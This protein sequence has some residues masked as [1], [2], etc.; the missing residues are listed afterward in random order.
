MQRKL[1]LP[2]VKMTK[3]KA[4]LQHQYS[5]VTEATW[6]SVPMTSDL[7]FGLIVHDTSMTELLKPNVMRWPKTGLQ[8]Q[9]ILE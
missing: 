1:F 4:G 8:G 2:I 6:V 5:R 7:T 9:N 3:G